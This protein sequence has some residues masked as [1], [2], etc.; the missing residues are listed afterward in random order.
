MR[1]KTVEVAKRKIEGE[2]KTGVERERELE[3]ERRWKPSSRSG[4]RLGGRQSCEG[5]LPERAPC[6][7]DGRVAQREWTS[8]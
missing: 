6:F 8:L 3:G 2:N 1:T 5:G 7:G 4:G